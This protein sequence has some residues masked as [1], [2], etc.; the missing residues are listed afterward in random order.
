MKPCLALF[1]GG[2]CAQAQAQAAQ[3]L[4][5]GDATADAGLGLWLAG[6]ALMAA[7]ALRRHG[8]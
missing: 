4:A 8:R 6:L 2:L 7:I 3:C 5:T 1:V